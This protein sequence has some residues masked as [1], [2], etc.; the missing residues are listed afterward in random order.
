MVVTILTQFNNND[1]VI[2]SIVMCRSAIASYITTG[3]RTPWLLILAETTML[4]PFDFN[5]A[6]F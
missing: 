4:S 5:N 1:A 2:S 6:I 3:G